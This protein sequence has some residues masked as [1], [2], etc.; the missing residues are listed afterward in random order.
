MPTY[1]RGP[2]SLASFP[3]VAAESPWAVGPTG[4]PRVGLAAS[5]LP[6]ANALGMKRE[7]SR[8]RANEQGDAGG[9]YGL[10]GRFP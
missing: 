2:G 7:G 4:L 8:R 1:T 10:N 5:D 9:D 3:S 6:P